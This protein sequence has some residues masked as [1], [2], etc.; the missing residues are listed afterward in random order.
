MGVREL[1]QMGGPFFYRIVAMGSHGS[2]AIDLLISR[3]S[4]NLDFT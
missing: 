1:G 2:L 3:E 4:L